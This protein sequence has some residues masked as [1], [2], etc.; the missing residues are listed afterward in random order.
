[1][2]GGEAREQTCNSTN[3]CTPVRVEKARIQPYYQ[4]YGR[5]EDDGELDG[6]ELSCVFEG[7]GKLGRARA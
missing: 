2:Q 7:R 5:V 4:M 1:M 3:R 6:G